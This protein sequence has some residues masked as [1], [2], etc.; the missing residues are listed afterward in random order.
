MTTFFLTEKNGKQTW[1]QC[2][3]FH[4]CIGKSVG[5]VNW[6]DFS[7]DDLWWSLMFPENP[8]LIKSVGH[9]SNH[10]DLDDMFFSWGAP[11][12]NMSWRKKNMS[13]A[14]VNLWG[15][16]LKWPFNRLLLIGC[17]FS[18][19]LDPS[20]GVRFHVKD[21]EHGWIDQWQF[22]CIKTYLGSK[23]SGRRKT[24]ISHLKK[25][26]CLPVDSYQLL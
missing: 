14:T 16:F 20:L 8:Y 24:T 12:L 21:D 23:M 22:L 10:H 4:K 18:K 5:E 3:R 15:G 26:S 7:W 19:P 1:W 13:P 11:S 17:T 9:F 2:R 25:L 6:G